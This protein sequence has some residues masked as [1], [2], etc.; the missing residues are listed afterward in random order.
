MLE[1]ENEW[2]SQINNTWNGMVGKVA[3]RKADVGLAAF[4][5]TIE[6]LSYVDFLAPII[7]SR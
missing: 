5:Y 4:T 6:R 1:P 3:E 7:C 2:G